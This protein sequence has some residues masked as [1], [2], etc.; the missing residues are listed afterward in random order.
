MA[1]AEERRERM[2]RMRFTA[3]LVAALASEFG[4]AAAARRKRFGQRLQEGADPELKFALAATAL[5]PD[6]V[7]AFAFDE[8]MRQKVLR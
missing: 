1:Y 4:P 2:R 7:P 3:A 8:S 6:N 5:G